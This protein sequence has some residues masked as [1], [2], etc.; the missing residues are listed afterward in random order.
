MSDSVD[1]TAGAIEFASEIASE[2][3]A[4]PCFVAPHGPSSPPQTAMVAHGVPSARRP[5]PLCTI[6]D[7]KSPAIASSP[8]ASAS[9]RNTAIT[10][11]EAVSQ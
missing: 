9:A 2:F 11:A 1:S 7:A 10:T 8:S 5:L 4:S 3:S 6:A